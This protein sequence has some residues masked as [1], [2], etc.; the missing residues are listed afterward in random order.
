MALKIPAKF[1]QQAPFDSST[2]SLKLDTPGLDVE[3]LKW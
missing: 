3:V 1:M 2:Q